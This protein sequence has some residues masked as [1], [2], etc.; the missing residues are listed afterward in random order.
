[1]FDNL[2]NKLLYILEHKERNVIFKI[3]RLSNQ[4]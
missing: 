1:M 2:L 3:P 4:E